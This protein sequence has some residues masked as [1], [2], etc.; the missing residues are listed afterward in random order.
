VD[1]ASRA[2]MIDVP[3]EGRYEPNV[4]LSVAYIKDGEM[5]THDRCSAF[6]L[7]VSS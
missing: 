6:L 5:Y 3:I 7:E 2:V 4:Y 1:A